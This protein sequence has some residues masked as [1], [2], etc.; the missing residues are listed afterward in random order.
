M[1]GSLARAGN[2][3][4]LEAPDIFAALDEGIIISILAHLTPLPDR[5]TAAAV[6]RVRA[7]VEEIINNKI[8]S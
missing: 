1:N 2:G 6:C 4:R 7:L 8:G 5:F 3:S